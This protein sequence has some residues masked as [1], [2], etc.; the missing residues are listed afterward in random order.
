MKAAKAGR[1]RDRVALPSCPGSTIPRTQIAAAERRK[2]FRGRDSRGDTKPA[3]HLDT[4]RVFRRSSSLAD[5]GAAHGLTTS[6][7][8]HPR[9]SR[10]KTMTHAHD[11]LQERRQA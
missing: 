3:A 2:T 1:I 9:L 4:R 11:S 7:D 5:E 8:G 10:G 6:L